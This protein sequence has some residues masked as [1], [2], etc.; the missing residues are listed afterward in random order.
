LSIEVHNEIALLH[1]WLLNR[2]ALFKG[3]LS[4]LMEIKCGMYRQTN[5]RTWI[6]LHAPI[7]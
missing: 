3:N 7:P 4:L 2:V 1:K 6:K 5:I